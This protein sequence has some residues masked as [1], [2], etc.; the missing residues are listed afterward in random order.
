MLWHL[1]GSAE[2]RSNPML[3]HSGSAEARSNEDRA[4]TADRW[5]RPPRPAAGTHKANYAPSTSPRNRRR[6][7]EAV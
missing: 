3:W 7:G 5:A 2:A 6:R 1:S 4:R